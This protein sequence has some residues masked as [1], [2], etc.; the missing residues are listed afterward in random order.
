M[1]LRKLR[2]HVAVASSLGAVALAA[3]MV[4]GGGVASATVP[5]APTAGVYPTW[6]P[7]DFSVSHIIRSSGSDTT[8]PMMQVLGDLYTGAGL[9]GCTL[10]STNT[11]C[12]TAANVD[13]T[14]TVDNYALT[15]ILTE[16]Q[17]HRFRQWSA[18][19]VRL[20]ELAGHRRLRPVVQ[21]DRLECQLHQLRGAAAERLRQGQCPGDGLPE[22]QPRR[23]G[24][25]HRLHRPD[26][27]RSG[28]P[29]H[30]HRRR[31]CRMAAGDPDQLRRRRHRVPRPARAPRSPTSTVERPAEP[32]A[33]PTGCGARPPSVAPP[34]ASPTGAS[35]PT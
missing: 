13:T 24:D 30:R 34:V 27:Q 25:G 35:S 5:P 19:A 11:N 23:G 14:D 21:A 6:I 33:S 3:T 29:Q 2:T 28:V 12:N 26:L 31:G 8:F 18:A 7:A 16:G 22:H 4:L 17:R 32:A 9:N 20:P 15:E 1:K 10:N